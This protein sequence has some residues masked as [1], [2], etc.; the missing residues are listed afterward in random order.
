MA[1]KLGRKKTIIIGLLISLTAF[2]SCIFINATTPHGDILFATCFIVAGFGLVCINVNTFPMVTE[3]ARGSNVG[4][5]TGYYYIASMAAQTFTP[6]LVGLV[7]ENFENQ[8][9]ALFIYSTIF[10]FLSMVSILFVKYGD[11]KPPKKAKAIEYFSD[12]DFNDNVEN[13]QVGLLLIF[14]AK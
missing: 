13:P 3:L 11:S 2:I 9:F 14:V 1:S 12:E 7:M 10:V 6:G 8:T 5:Y 4:R